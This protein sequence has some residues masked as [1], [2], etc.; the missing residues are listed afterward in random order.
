MKMNENPGILA[1]KHSGRY[2][3]WIKNGDKTVKKEN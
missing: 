2:T 1:G 3:I